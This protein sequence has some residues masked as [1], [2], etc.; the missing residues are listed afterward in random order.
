MPIF[1]PQENLIIER[2]ATYEGGGGIK[3]PGTKT[4][5][6]YLTNTRLIFEYTDG[7]ISKKTF[8]PMDIPVSKIRNVSGEGIIFKTLVIEFEKFDGTSGR[9]KFST[10]GFDEWIR[11]IH[12]CIMDK[13]KKDSR[14]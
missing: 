7:L 2:T 14:E 5:I 1:P 9:M 8:T 12:M 4:G 6:L 10:S 13:I 11:E 3:I